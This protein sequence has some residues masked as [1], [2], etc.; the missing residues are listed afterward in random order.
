MHFVLK[1]TSSFFKSF[2]DFFL[3]IR[4]KDEIIAPSE[5]MDF[6]ISRFV[7]LHTIV[8]ITAADIFTNLEDFLH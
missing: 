3:D 2:L 8:L 1:R 4:R 5:K 7:I 6:L